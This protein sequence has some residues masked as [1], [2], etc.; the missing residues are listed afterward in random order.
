MDWTTL[1]LVEN[2]SGHLTGFWMG[3]RS[4]CK[5]LADNRFFGMTK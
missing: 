5:H 3:N 2:S 1:I 4:D